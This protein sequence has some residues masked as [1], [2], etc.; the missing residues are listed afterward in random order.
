V[1]LV[2]VFVRLSCLL[3]LNLVASIFILLGNAVG[4]RSILAAMLLFIIIWLLLV[5]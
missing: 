1:V 2:A 4:T 3:L 5:I